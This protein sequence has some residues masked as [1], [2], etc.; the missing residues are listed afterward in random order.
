MTEPRNDQE[1]QRQ[2]DELAARAG[3]LIDRRTM[4]SSVGLKAL[5]LPVLVSLSVTPTA[6]AQGTGSPGVSMMS[7]FPFPS[8]QESRKGMMSSRMM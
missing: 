2:I 1:D 3:K 4:I 5:A 8:L 6:F 7:M